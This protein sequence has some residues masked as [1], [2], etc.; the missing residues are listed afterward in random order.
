M[1]RNLLAL[2]NVIIQGITGAHGAFHAGIMKASGATIIAGTSPNKAGSLV[3]GIP[4]FATIADIKR[5]HDSID[6]SIVFVPPKFA[7]LAMIEA[8]DAHIPLIICITE[9]VP[10]H[11]MLIVKNYALI[12]GSV[13]IGPNCPGLLIPGEGTFGI[14]PAAMGLPGRIAIVSRSGTLA[15]EVTEGL[16]RRKKGQRYVI[17]IGGDR[18]QGT[19]FIDC[20]SLFQEDPDV[21]SIILIGEIGGKSE[22]KAAEYIKQHVTKSVYAYIAG[23]V[24]PPGVQLGHAGAILGSSDE[25]ALAKT[26]RL[27]QAG[28]R[29]F[30]TITSLIESVE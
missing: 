28:A 3:H 9:G 8:I 1:H 2:Q 4:V 11:D 10:I 14:I 23:R 26:T 20:L 12:H 19:S 21:S 27:K 18:I 30:T 6:A 13:I 17:G 5:Q 16:T 25:S 15:Y 22:Q 24:A 7:K 29:T